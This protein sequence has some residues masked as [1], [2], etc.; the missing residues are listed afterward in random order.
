MSCT[1]AAPPRPLASPSPPPLLVHTI[2]TD[3]HAAEEK[4]E[5]EEETTEGE[6]SERREEEEEDDRTETGA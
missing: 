6:V 5:G 2:D 3:A 1:S 4:E